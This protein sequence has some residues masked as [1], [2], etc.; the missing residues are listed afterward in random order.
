MLVLVCH[1]EDDRRKNK[2][3]PSGH[4]SFTAT[5]TRE[6]RSNIVLLVKRV[7]VDSLSNCELMI[8][9]SRLVRQQ[10][11][12]GFDPR[13]KNTQIRFLASQRWYTSMFSCCSS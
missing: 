6:G 8:G 12:C 13:T 10:H 7:H 3:L 5:V 9:E 11:V 1:L 4:K 2:L